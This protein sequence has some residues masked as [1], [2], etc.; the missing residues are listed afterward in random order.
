MIDAASLVDGWEIFGIVYIDVLQALTSLRHLWSRG[1]D[2]RLGLSK[3]IKCERSQV[4]VLAS[5]IL[6]LLLIE[7]DDSIQSADLDYLQR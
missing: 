3:D 6:L 2:S 5:A 7:F 4:R 1:Y